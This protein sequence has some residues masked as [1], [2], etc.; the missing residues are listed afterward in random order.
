MS[1]AELL[2][3]G[4]YRAIYR[5]AAGKRRSAGTFAASRGPRPEKAAETAAAVAEADARALGWR[6]PS[7]ALK[8]WGAWCAE[9]WLTRPVEP[10]TLARDQSRRDSRLMPR[11]GAVPL[12]DITRH[13]VKAWAA[14]LTRSGLAPSTV[15]KCVYLLSASLAAAVDAEVITAN[16]A[17]QIKIVTGQTDAHRYLSTSEADVLIDALPSAFDVALVSLML[18]TG[19]RWGEAVGLRIERV[20]L[21]RG[22]LRV[23]EVWD[24]KLSRL[25]PYP[26]GRRQRSVPMPDWVIERIEPLIGDRSTGYVFAVGETVPHH[27]NWRSRVWLPSLAASGVGA[28]RVHDLRHT[29]ASWL[30]ADGMSLARIGKLLG[31]VSPLTTQAYAHLEDIERADV[32]RALPRPG[33]G[34]DVG[35]QT[36]APRVR[37]LRLVA[38]ASQ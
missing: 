34:A 5:D 14:E 21:R 19:L 37:A 13:E 32:L 12:V 38:G 31:H 35:Q 3:S 22:E 25:K 9:W 4:K 30:I 15:Q 8:T 29:Y 20:D 7:A 2:P 11:W 1:Y 26:K 27:S 6:D 23:A 28:L 17:A 24:G 36:T 16:P 33:R 10:G 18:G